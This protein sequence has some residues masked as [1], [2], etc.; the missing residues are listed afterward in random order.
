MST[1]LEA[2]QTQVEP[3]GA[4]LGAEDKPWQAIVWNDPVNLMSYVTYVFQKLF[5]YSRDHATKL[6][7]DVHH[8]GKAVVSWGTKEKVEGDVAKLHAAGLWATMQQAP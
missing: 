6:M 1:P 4:E 3:I 5:G 2:E 8:K 7:L